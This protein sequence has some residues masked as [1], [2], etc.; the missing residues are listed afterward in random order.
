MRLFGLCVTALG[1]EM[2]ML[3]GATTECIDSELVKSSCS[4]DCSTKTWKINSV[5]LQGCNN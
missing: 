2:F 1:S 3:S 5:I 4:L